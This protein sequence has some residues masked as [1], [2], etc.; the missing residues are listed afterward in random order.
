[1]VTI[2]KIA[3]TEA[4]IPTEDEEETTELE[5]ERKETGKTAEKQ[6]TKDHAKEVTKIGIKTKDRALGTEK[7]GGSKERRA[8]IEKIVPAIMQR[9]RLLP[10]LV[11]VVFS[12]SFSGSRISRGKQRQKIHGESG[13]F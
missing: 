9:R 2:V 13:S 7:T 10:R 11:S 1:M 8:T 5:A 6:T 4:E 3:K 12:Q